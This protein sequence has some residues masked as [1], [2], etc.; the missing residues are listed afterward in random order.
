M[1]TQLTNVTADPVGA[2]RA[3]A[4]LGETGPLR[5]VLTLMTGQMP[6]GVGEAWS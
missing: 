5:G 1:E 2:M 4:E 3:V 6:I